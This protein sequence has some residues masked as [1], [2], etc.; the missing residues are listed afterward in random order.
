MTDLRSSISLLTF[1]NVSDGLQEGRSP[2]VSK[3][4]HLAQS[5]GLSITTVSRAL[6]GYS[7]VA[8]A[9][10]KRVQAAA[11]ALNYRPNSAARSLRRRKAEAVAV[12]L[13]LEPGRFGPA[14]FLNMLGACS[15]IG[16]KPLAL[17]LVSGG[18]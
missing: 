14:V 12:T 16:A 3:L 13:P 2:A 7:D 10:R 8:P 15:V 18:R 9:T 17:R 5:L 1:Q 11:L 6:D 4:K